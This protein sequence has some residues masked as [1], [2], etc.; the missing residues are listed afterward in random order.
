MRWD[1]RL[2]STLTTSRI[3]Q[4]VSRTAVAAGSLIGM[5]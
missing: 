3:P 2:E 1:A 4:M 5:G